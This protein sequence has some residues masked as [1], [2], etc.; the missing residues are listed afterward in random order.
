MS[1]PVQSLPATMPL[2]FSDF[3][4]VTS[5]GRG[6]DNTVVALREGRSALA[7]CTFDDFPFPTYVGEIAGLDA[8]PL[9][10][11]FAGFDCRNNRL[12]AITLR[13]DNFIESVA[14]ARQRHG[15]ARIGVFVGTST[16]GLQQTEAAYRRLDPITGRL[17]PDFDYSR[18]HNTYSLARFVREALGLA[19]PAFVVSTACAATAKVFATAAR[20]IAADVC[21]AAV[22]GGA[23]TLCA[24]TLYGFHSLGVMSEEPC[25]PFNSERCGISIGEAAGFV[26]LERPDHRHGADT[27]LLLGYGES[28]DAYHM[29]SPHPEGLG[30]RLALEAALASA[31]MKPDAID[32]IN[33]HG[34]ATS[35][36]DSAEDRA[37]FDV[38]GAATPCNS[39][40]GFAGHTLGASGVVEAAFCALAMQNEFVPGSPHTRSVDPRLKSRYVREGYPVH[41]E[42]VVS[43]SFG[44]GGANCSIVL[45]IAT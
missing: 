42:R 28:S 40:K 24:T 4:V 8:A 12:A 16:S 35:V 31:G 14:V 18:T 37:V 5:L 2:A 17:P 38:F 20:M 1:S 39:T 33:L 7:S 9:R 41:I 26:L 6:R 36:G 30:A 23:D 45:G 10:G 44:F 27:I 15:A 11:E 43:N 22:V 25:R 34:T 19:G 29:S 32:Y 21:D 13:E 3:T